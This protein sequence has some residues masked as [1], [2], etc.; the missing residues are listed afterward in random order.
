MKYGFIITGTIAA[1]HYDFGNDY[2]HYFN[3]YL[4]ILHGG[5]SWEEIVNNQIIRNNEYGW[6][7]IYLLFTPFGQ[8][9]FFG[10][11]ALIS[12]IEAF[13]YYYTIKKFVNREWWWLAVFI[14]LFSIS[15]Y[16]MNFSMLRQGLVVSVFVLILPW[17]I[18]KKF[19]RCLITIGILSTIHSSAIVLLPFV[20]LPYL[21]K[22]NGKAFMIIICG[23]FIA[24]FFSRSFL[25]NIFTKFMAVDQFA[26]YADIYSLG[27][28]R[29]RK[30]GLGFLI[31]L[32][33]FIVMLWYVATHKSLSK[34]WFVMITLSSI[35]YIVVPFAELLQV[36]SRV[37][38]YFTVFSLITIPLTYQCI[39]N[40]VIRVALLGLYMLFILYDY[41]LFFSNPVWIEHFST[42]KTIF[43]VI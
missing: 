20:F 26:N 10:V 25:E 14:Y 37:S 38:I 35:G 43:E 2:L 24:T 11:V 21:P 6:G 36:I 23:L 28:G 32:I 42:Y 27:A 12:I 4:S 29:D 40:K 33:P 30:Y 16:V 5:Y 13:A 41:S 19:I 8:S 18:E 9:G 7:L 1:V 15:I 39:K 22:I 3:G 31:K 34:T 17:I